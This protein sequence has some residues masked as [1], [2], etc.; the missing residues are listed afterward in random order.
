M[1]GV[2]LSSPAPVA[3]G[4]IASSWSREDCVQPDPFYDHLHQQWPSPLIWVQC[5]LRR[6]IVLNMV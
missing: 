4:E 2:S 3:G 6:R 1:V 5:A